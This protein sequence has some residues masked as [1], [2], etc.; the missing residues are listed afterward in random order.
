[1][2]QPG[3]VLVIGSQ[4]AKHLGHLSVLEPRPLS[5]KDPRWVHTP[6][7][8]LFDMAMLAVL[9]LFY[10]GFVRWKIRLTHGK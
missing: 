3:V 8:W 7:A 4:I 6:S 1:M 9:S 2:P 5:P 10:A